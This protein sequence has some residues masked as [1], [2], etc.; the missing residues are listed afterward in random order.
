MHCARLVA[1]LVAPLLVLSAA[2]AQPAG[3]T[4]DQPFGHRGGIGRADAAPLNNI[5]PNTIPPKAIPVAAAPAGAGP[6]LR[7]LALES[8]YDAVRVPDAPDLQPGG[9]LT[10]E[11]WVKRL[12]ASGCGTLVSKDR[13]ASYWLALCDGRLRFSAGGPGGEGASTVPEGRWTHVAVAYDG[14]TARFYV[15]GA[16]DRSVPLPA[17]QPSATPADLSLGADTQPGA[18]FYGRMDHVRLWS[19][20]RSEAQLRD[21]GLATLGPQAG[22]VAQWPLDGDARDLAGGHDGRPDLG[23]Y[24]VDGVLPRGLAIPTAPAAVALDGRCDPAEY[25][26]AER[27]V[28]EGVDA[29]VVYVQA[30]AS[31][32]YACLPDLDRPTNASALVAVLLD[33]NLSRDMRAQPGDYRFSVKHGGNPL[34]EEG[35]GNGGWKAVTLAAG[36]WEAA[37][38][39]AGDRWSAELRLARSLLEPPRDPSEP[40]QAGLAVG[41]LGQR[42]AGDDNVWPPAGVAGSPASWATATLADTDRPE[43]RFAFSGRVQRSDAEGRQIGVGDAVLRLYRLEEDGPPVLADSTVSDGGG[44]WTLSWTGSTPDRLVIDETDPPGHVSLAATGPMPG[45][46]AGAN[47]LVYDLDEA[48]LPPETDYRDL[49]FVD[50]LGPAV[51]EPLRRHYLVVY[52]PPVAEADLWPLV[53]AKRT[54]GFRVTARSTEDL[55][56]TGTGRDLA[57]RIQSWL[58]AVWEAA[59]EDGEPVYALLVGRG[60]KVPFRD[61]GWLADDHRQPGRPDYRP[62][63]PT[64]WYYADLDSDWD[65]DGDGYFGEFLGCAPG[66]QY[67]DTEGVLQDCPEAGSLLREGPYGALRG[68]EDDFRVEIGLGRLAVNEPAAVRSALAGLARSELAFGPERRRALVA[69]AFWSFAGQGWSEERRAVVPGSDSRADPWLRAAW[70]GE[71]PYGQDAGEALE[72]GLLPV[73]SGLMQETF[74]LYETSAPGG[75]ALLAP[76]RLSPDAALGAADMTSQLGRSPGWVVAAGRGDAAGLVAAHWLHDWDADGRIDQPALPTAC[77]GQ[78]VDAGQE[79]PPCRELLAEPFLGP[80]LPEGVPLPPVVVANAGGTGAVAWSYAGVDGGGSVIQPLAGPPAV[81]GRLAAQGWLA[82]WVGSLG[83]MEPGRLDGFQASLARHAL[84]DGLS[85]GDATGQALSELARRHEHDLRAYGVALFGDPAYAYWGSVPDSWGAWPEDGGDRRASGASAYNGPMVPERAWVLSGAGAGTAPVVGRHGELVLGG[86]GRVVRVAGSGLV[87]A[88]G[89]AGTAALR[90]PAA[91][92]KGQV[93]AATGGSVWRFDEALGTPT[94]LRLPAGA[95]A[96]GAPRR[97]ADGLLYVPTQQG[98]ARL[99]GAGRAVLVSADGVRGS[100]ALRPSGELVWSTEAGRVEGYRVDQA[101]QAT[102]RSLNNQDLGE[103][104]PPAVSPA[105]TVYVGSSNGRAYAWPEDGPG[106]QLEA[107]GAVGVRPAIGPDGTVY[108]LNSR[109][110]L[111]AFGAERRDLLWRLDLG[112]VA[113]ASASVDQALVYVVAGGRLLAV[114]RGLGQAAWSV[115]LGGATDGRSVPV[116]GPDRTVYVARADQ[117]LVAVREAGWLAAP[118][119]VRLE[120][121]TMGAAVRWRDNS[122]GARGFRVLLCPETQDCVEAGTAPAGSSRLEVRRLPVAVGEPFHARVQALG[123]EPAGGEARV[124]AAPEDAHRDSELGSSDP[125]AAMPARPGAPTGLVAEARAADRV[126]LRWRYEGDPEALTG[127]RVER[128]VGQ[129]WLGLATLGPDERDFVDA[130]L[131]ADHAYRYRVVALGPAG[132]SAEGIAGARTR[133]EGLVA[134]TN[135]NATTL[136]DAV[137]LTWREGNVRET[138]VVVERLDP[139]MASY[140]PLAQ[141]D[142]D[143]GQFRDHYELVP[144]LYTYRLRPVGEEVDGPWRTLTVRFGERSG[145]P[146]YLPLTYRRR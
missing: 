103:L 84:G 37:R 102:R 69:G 36:S 82:A 110:Q 42:A 139:G 86:T 34:V 144:G 146:L 26:A 124:L 27:V 49:T 57:E 48:E 52:A 118:S 47:A 141:L 100:P 104:T 92:A 131:V 125:Q 120:T 89:A 43:A 21:N 9:A 127:F 23:S 85:L 30:S 108:L 136:D 24:G 66:A 105:G 109:G 59:E 72:S 83:P 35:D 58:K 68:P 60:D 81:P 16:L 45:T 4:P 3:A 74:R 138:G 137:V 19:V 140:R 80:G 67:R 11:L 22:L 8:E 75:D 123:P 116:L 50:A 122:P 13:R 38:T 130:E 76:T 117:A 20:V 107:G 39:T 55:G 7:G 126:A 2:S 44:R 87:V 132:A 73:L 113:S 56:R 134:I 88:Q 61:I 53:A 64:D 106:W 29:W 115:D 15:N 101:G 28:L 99:D 65:V 142:A 18:F 79:G 94:E 112:A 51:P 63:W 5:P 96:S 10:L 54:A 77:A 31:N 70:T 128:E 41:Y 95:T 32:V 25:G 114:S 40:V 78:P 71:K 135:L 33:R 121:G 6:T 145:R 90:Y 91:L 46:A 97:G 62:A 129:G 133:R 119:D 1:G 98:L 143:A 17:E 14:T 93:V 111:L 12:R